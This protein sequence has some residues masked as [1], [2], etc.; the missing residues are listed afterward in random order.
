[1]I[2][3]P[4]IRTKGP[5][6]LGATGPEGTGLL[7]RWPRPQIAADEPDEPDGLASQTLV[8]TCWPRTPIS[9]T[10]GQVTSG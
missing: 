4:L 5:G 7:G 8:C 1:M 2:P 10:R 3:L 6:V 9:D